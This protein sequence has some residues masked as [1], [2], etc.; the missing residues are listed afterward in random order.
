M[1]SGKTTP[2]RA[3]REALTDLQAAGFG[4]MAAIGS[5]FAEAMNEIG[6][7]AVRFMA[8]RLEADMETRRRILSCTDVHDLRAVQAD[9]V[10]TSLDQ[11]SEETGRML[12]IG[13]KLMKTAAARGAG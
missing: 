4:T 8:R 2:D 9:F 10:R 12:E 11:Y 5:A 3:A 13:D 6:S 1:I 7:E